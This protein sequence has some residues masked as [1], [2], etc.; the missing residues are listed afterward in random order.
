MSVLAYAGLTYTTARAGTASRESTS[1]SMVAYL[2][3][4]A[5]KGVAMAS[6]VGRHILRTVAT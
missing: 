4:T 6:K 1:S 5:E 2:G 3:H